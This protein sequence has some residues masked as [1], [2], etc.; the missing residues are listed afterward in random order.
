[1]Q[2]KVV[3]YMLSYVAKNIE[4]AIH[5]IYLAIAVGTIALKSSSE[6]LFQ[7]IDNGHE[8]I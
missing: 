3:I 2:N 8:I 7:E 1:M 6:D 5:H 4:N